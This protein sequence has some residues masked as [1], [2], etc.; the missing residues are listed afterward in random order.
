MVIYAQ[1]NN[2]RQMDKLPTVWPLYAPALTMVGLGL[3]MRSL[4]G[5]WLSRIAIWSGRVIFVVMGFAWELSTNSPL[6]VRL[7][8]GVLA[9]FVVS[10]V[11]S[12]I[13]G[14]LCTSQQANE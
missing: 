14:S 1:Y 4:W 8:N 5:V 7:L 11:F 12:K 13:L 2:H 10:V 3:A 6:W 9:A